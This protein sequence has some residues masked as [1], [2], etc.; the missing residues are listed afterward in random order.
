MEVHAMTTLTMRATRLRTILATASRPAPRRGLLPLAILV[1]GL[2]EL[3]G[4]ALGLWWLTFV[5]GIA[6]GWLGGRR[7]LGALVAGTLLGWTVGILLQS[8]GR[9]LD[10]GGFVSAMVLGAKG[11]GWVIVVI[12]L[13]YALLV[14]S[15]GAWLGA[16][17]RR[18]VLGSRGRAAEAQAAPVEHVPAERGH[19]EPSHVEG[20]ASV[21][22]PSSVELEER[23][24]V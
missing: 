18:L 22:E 5:V 19:V 3:G 24:H 17:A 13:V 7:Y 4:N 20:P 16:A 9:T 15:A 23:E 12:T 11:L 8:G 1:V 2:V 6:A 21:D 14:A 10:V